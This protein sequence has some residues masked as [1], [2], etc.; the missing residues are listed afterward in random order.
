MLWTVC[1]VLLILWILGALGGVSLPVI[2][3]DRVHVLLIL[4]VLIVL[5]EVLGGRR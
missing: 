5:V 1:V 2:S 3:G 4:V